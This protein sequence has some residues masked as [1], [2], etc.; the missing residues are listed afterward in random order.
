MSVPTLASLYY[1]ACV[2][3]NADEVARLSELLKPI[4]T[5]KEYPVIISTGIMKCSSDAVLTWW[6]TKWFHKGVLD[7]DEEGA[8]FVA[9]AH[10]QRHF[11]GDACLQLSEDFL[12]PSVDTCV[13][14]KRVVIYGS[15]QFEAACEQRRIDV[16]QR[17]FDAHPGQCRAGFNIALWKVCDASLQHKRDVG[18]IQRAATARTAR[19]LL[20]TCY[21]PA[22]EKSVRSNFLLVCRNPK[23]NCGLVAAFLD[24]V[25]ALV[26]PSV[27]DAFIQACSHGCWAV[28]SVLPVRSHGG[29]TQAA[30][31][32]GFLAACVR[33]DNTRLLW[34]LVDAHDVAAS[35]M[36]RG[37]LLALK[38]DNAEIVKYLTPLVAGAG[39]VDWPATILALCP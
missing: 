8:L 10:T 37:V 26:A 6:S 11:L 2:S 25:P 16:L 15:S 20:E 36:A 24:V 12:S 7:H 22:H 23:A 31:D 28:A 18:P 35:V 1:D 13:Y 38:K 29:V 19:W 17:M 4:A 39:N 34:K 9:A 14:T 27:N 32:E 30:I 21:A 3:G 5:D 33:T